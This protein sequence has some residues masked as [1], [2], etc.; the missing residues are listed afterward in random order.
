M[1]TKGK[2][3]RYEVDV[4]NVTMPHNLEA[5]QALLGC[6]MMDSD[7]QLDVMSKLTSADFF[8]DSHKYIYE[9]MED[10]SKDTKESRVVD[11]TTI[12]D[13]LDKE[14][15]LESAG[16]IDYLTSLTTIL[17]S[18]ANYKQYLEIVLRDGAMRRLIKGSSE[19]IA[20]AQTSQD[21]Q[22]AIN[23]AEKIVFDL[24]SSVDTTEMQK[25]NTVLPEVLNKLDLVSKDKNALRGISSGFKRLDYMLNGLHPTDFILIAA[26]PAMGKTSFAM[27]IVENV[28]TLSNK[29][30]AVFS[31]E[32]GKEQ[33]TQRMLCSLAEVSMEDAIKGNL[34]KD[35]WY[36]IAAAREKL[37]KA[38]IFIN[39]STLITPTEILSQCRRLKKKYG[40]DL[41]MIDYIQLMSSGGSKTAD[42]RQQEVSEIS[43]GLKILAKELKVPVIALSQLSRSVESRSDHRPQLSDI[44][45]SGAIEQDAD[46]VMFIHR[47]DYYQN[48]ADESKQ[49][50]HPNISEIIVAKHRNG[51]TGTV[52]LFFKSECTK[53]L[54]VEKRDG[55]YIVVSPND[56]AMTAHEASKK[57]NDDDT[58]TPENAPNEENDVPFAPDKKHENPLAYEDNN[59]EDEGEYSYD[60][61]NPDDEIFA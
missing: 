16:G 27:N 45:E 18:S 48:Q 54:N 50:A 55:Q 7:I 42:N 31:L 34:S 35:Q 51:P 30:C 57:V 13:K 1:Q 29:V 46:I 26:R 17:P 4:K 24:A 38:K 12:L 9:A 58:V 59:E 5:E 43:R 49:P 11:F 60:D 47:P 19:I 3:N 10:L 6:I 8:V 56:G 44:R 21:K 53:F 52:E 40:L 37:A 14:G 33:L 41:I 32:M 61:D 39:D 22:D 23:Y 36:K 20:R 2:K 28:A 15:N 25:I